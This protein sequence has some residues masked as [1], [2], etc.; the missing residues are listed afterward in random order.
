MTADIPRR[1]EVDTTLRLELNNQI[2]S[3]P[4]IAVV[5]DCDDETHNFA[6]STVFFANANS[7]IKLSS[8]REL[9]ISNTTAQPVFTLTLIRIR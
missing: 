3:P 7:L 9:T 6:G 5:T 1:T 4:E 2:I 8:L